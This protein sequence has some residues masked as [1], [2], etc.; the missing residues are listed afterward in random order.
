M[1]QAVEKIKR[2]VQVR[3]ANA[4]LLLA[5]DEGD[6]SSAHN[7]LQQEANVCADNYKALCNAVA[8]HQNAIADLC[9]STINQAF[10]NRALN[11]AFKTACENNNIEFIKFSLDIHN[12]RFGSEANNAYLDL[13]CDAAENGNI[14]IVKYLVNAGTNA[15]AEN[16]KAI[17]VAILKQHYEIAF[18]L[19][20]KSNKKFDVT[21]Q[22]LCA[23]TQNSNDSVLRYFLSN[24]VDP[25]DLFVDLYTKLL[26]TGMVQR[27]SHG[28]ILLR[29]V[30][31]ENATFV[32]KAL[33]FGI[34]SLKEYGQLI[35]FSLTHSR[36]DTFMALVELAPEQPDKYLSNVQ[37]MFNGIDD[38]INKK[39]K[40]LWTSA[41]TSRALLEVALK[42][43]SLVENEEKAINAIPQTNSI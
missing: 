5:I 31:D 33:E 38:E 41:S 9:M 27:V 28:D 10:Y 39:N 14:E 24:E 15:N 11:F 32:R 36:P 7:A 6:L 19:C 3:Q 34:D 40:A 20:Q 35:S 16:H 2:I 17:N 43:T 18:F 13:L 42:N 1:N 37:H 23:A 4:Q 30:L 8:G 22:L 25:D 12:F 26:D 29:A 21:Y